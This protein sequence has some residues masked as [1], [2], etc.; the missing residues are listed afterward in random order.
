[1]GV[2]SSNVFTGVSA[3]D[4]KERAK[5]EKAVRDLEACANVNSAHIQLGAKGLHVRRIQTALIELDRA[6]IPGPELKEDRYG[7]GTAQAVANF[8]AKPERNIL[9][10]A[11]KIDPIVGINTIRRMDRELKIREGA[12]IPPDLP[13]VPPTD[14]YIRILGLD[15]GRPIPDDDP[16]IKTFKAQINTPGYLKTHL[17]VQT[18]WSTGSF[19]TPKAVNAI[20]DK[21]RFAKFDIVDRVFLLGISSGGKNVIQLANRLFNEMKLRSRFIGVGDAAF[22]KNDPLFKNPGP[23]AAQCP[24]KQNWFQTVGNAID[25]TGEVHDHIAG[26]VDK[27]QDNLPEVKAAANVKPSDPKDKRQQAA[28]SAHNAAVAVCLREG[29]QRIKQILREGVVD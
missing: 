5:E 24:E 2:L 21:I 15:V 26:F 9:N 27:R 23:G 3:T 16:A 12:L 19:T 1:M 14:I 8:K 18:F 29:H 20:L 17:P 4:P 13:K 7:G 25:P 28:N 11:G 6:G 10:F 22:D